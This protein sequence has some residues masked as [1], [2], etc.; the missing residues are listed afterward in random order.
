MKKFIGRLIISVGI[1]SML[2]PMLSEGMKKNK[3]NEL[4]DSF[5]EG[6]PT[7]KEDIRLAEV[8]EK[9]NT[10]VNISKDGNIKEGRD[11]SD[12]KDTRDTKEARKIKNTKEGREAEEARK[13]KNAENVKV[14]KDIRKIKNTEN[15]KKDKKKLKLIDTPVE[16]K[17]PVD[18]KHKKQ[19]KGD[20]REERNAYI[21]SKWPV[22][23]ILEI[24][25]I[26]LFMPIIEGT[27]EDNLDVSICSIKGCNKPWT[28]GNYAIA[29]H[30][31][32]RYGWNFN[33]L[34]ELV[35]G[36]KVEI[37]S[38]KGVAYAYEVYEVM[39]V[40]ETDVSVLE[41]QDYDEITLITCDPIGKKNPEYRLVVK[42][43]KIIYS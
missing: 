30:R 36:D 10:I 18:E 17:K 1:L 40:H 3:Q 15:A 14:A 35:V 5:Q 21:M 39:I 20:T 37:K 27:Q 38:I 6:M 32:L 22:E 13:I 19:E 31:S 9:Q 34:D 33:R 42:A 24:E 11:I 41:Q 2:Y 26:D 12:V 8:L 43:K 16:N 7:V 29:G 28:S 23:G 4:L 25:K